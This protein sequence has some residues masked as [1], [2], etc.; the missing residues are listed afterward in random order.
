MDRPPVLDDALACLVDGAGDCHPSVL[1]IGGD[2]RRDLSLP[3]R[4]Q[5][6]V[7]PLLVGAGLAP[8]GGQ[9]DDVVAQLAESVRKA[10]PASM[11][12]S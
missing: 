3:K 11:E 10:P 6:V 12:D 9:R 8:V 2:G 7:F 1:G 4:H 5:G